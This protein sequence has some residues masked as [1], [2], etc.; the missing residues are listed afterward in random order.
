MKGNRYLVFIAAILA[1]VPQA[2][3][4]K[5][6][7]RYKLE[8]GARHEVCRH[9]TKVF[10]ARFRTP[11]DRG[12]LSLEQ[13]P[14]TSDG[15]PY[16]Q[17]FERLP[18]VEYNKEFVFAMLLSKYPT[19]PEFDAVQWKESR[20]YYSLSDSIDGRVVKIRHSTPL[21][22]TSL[23]IDNDG[24]E[25]WLVK[26]DFRG[27]PSRNDDL[28][29]PSAETI[30]IYDRDTFDPYMEMSEENKAT[31]WDI[32]GRILWGFYNVRPF[33]HRQITYVA[34]YQAAWEDR[35][36]RPMDRHD[37]RSLQLYPDAEYMNIVRVLSG[38]GEFVAPQ[39][40]YRAAKT[41]TVCRIRMILL[42]KPNNKGGR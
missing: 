20:F 31:W 23:D 26:R 27:E 28:F 2:Y 35:P 40:T 37:G 11:W 6:Y 7:Y 9:M 1:Q 12:W 33:V 32:P 39:A 14:R 18:G 19:S 10:N 15:I 8:E 21:L 3:A 30:M 24:R 34:A 17:V 38:E 16:D 29:N 42:N 4:D 5:D 41:E 13:V 36:N 22:V 25:D